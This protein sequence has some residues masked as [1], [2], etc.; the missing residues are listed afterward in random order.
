MNTLQKFEKKWEESRF[1][2]VGLD[3]EYEKLPESIRTPDRSGSILAFN[4]AIIDASFDLVGSYKINS[5]FYEAEGEDGAAALQKTVDYIKTKDSEMPVILDAKRADIGNTNNGYV[6]SAFDELKV[7]AI[8]V[9]PYL[10]QEALEPFLAVS[11]KL[12]IVLVKTSNPGSGEFQDLRIEGSGLK[13]YEVVANKISEKWNKNGNLGVV[14]GATYPE[15][16]LEIRKIIGDMPI[17]IPGI[18]AQGG[19]VD[20]TVKAGLDSHK[21]GI[22][23]HSARGIIYASSKAD[24]AEAARAATQKLHE[25]IIASIPK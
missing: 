25:E 19:D 9:N 17:L 21:S 24:F 7:D 1:V 3:T 13:L 18:G 8:T 5:A 6:K 10:G 15:E 14:V 20:A 11:D 16:L 23:V 4:K 2:C 22:I 12:I